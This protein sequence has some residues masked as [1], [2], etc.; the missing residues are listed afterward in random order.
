MPRDLLTL[1]V[2]RVFRV[3]RNP[4]QP[5]CLVSDY[6]RTRSNCRSELARDLLI[7]AVERVWRVLR[8]RT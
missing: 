6:R 8:A 7:L 3:L 5:S 1:I 2:E 4:S